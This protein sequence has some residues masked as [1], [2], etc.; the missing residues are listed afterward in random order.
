MVHFKKVLKVMDR[1]TNKIK[2]TFCGNK[3]GD[4]L[5]KSCC[6]KSILLFLCIFICS[7]C[8]LWLW[9]SI[10]KGWWANANAHAH[11]GG[12]WSAF[13]DKVRYWFHSVIIVLLIL[14]ILIRL[15]TIITITLLKF[16]SANHSTIRQDSKP[17]D[18]YILRG[19]LHMMW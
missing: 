8:C 5:P 11:G 9:S 4:T 2:K 19:A 18:K 12:W 17:H 10:S 13:L 16:I 3:N 14:M 7:A 15:N 6:S 1:K